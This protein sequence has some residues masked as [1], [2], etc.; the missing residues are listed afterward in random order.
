MYA[1]IYT[2][3]PPR[4][5]LNS[6]SEFPASHLSPTFSPLSS[7]YLRSSS[8]RSK[9]GCSIPALQQHTYLLSTTKLK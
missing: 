6:P 5:S 4:I 3:P 9:H 7:S 8:R 2:S 1:H